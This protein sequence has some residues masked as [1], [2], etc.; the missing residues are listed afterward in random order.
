M[1]PFT[2]NAFDP[3]DFT[4]MCLYKIPKINRVTTPAFELALS[5]LFLSGA[6][7][8]VEIPEGMAH[9]PGYVKKYLQKLPTGWDDVKFID[10]FP[11]EYVVLA[12]KAGNKWYIAG[13]NGTPQEKSFTLDLNA[14][15]A[16]KAAMLTNSKSGHFIDQKNMTL[17]P[18]Q[19]E[20]ITLDAHDG[21]VMVLE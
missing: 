17:Q 7:H 18:G 15:K 1:L 4:P 8:F 21:F 13:I 6:Q 11:G 19:K 20:N 12:R 10:G 5:V 16:K 9:M 2:R 3:M 14:F